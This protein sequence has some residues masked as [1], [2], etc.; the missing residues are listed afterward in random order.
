MAAVRRSEV[1]A[2]IMG[3]SHLDAIISGG[4]KKGGSPRR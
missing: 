1:Q 4:G 3:E 2:N